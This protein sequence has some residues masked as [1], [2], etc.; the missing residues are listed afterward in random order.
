MRRVSIKEQI[1]F[2]L[3]ENRIKFTLMLIIIILGFSAGIFFAGSLS[4][5][6]GAEL[7]SFIREFCVNTGLETVPLGNIFKSAILSHL[8]LFIIIFLSGFSVIFVPV[9]FCALGLKMFEIGFTIGFMSLYFGLKGFLLAFAG[10]LSQII[11]LLPPIV[12]FGVQAINYANERKR[13]KTTRMSNVKQNE[14]QEFL[15]YINSALFCL[16]F[17]VISCLV[18]TFIT[19]VFIRSIA[20]ALLAKLSETHVC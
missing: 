7:S 19:P 20:P 10:A 11:L 9:I 17:I 3:E 18:E 15:N 13:M 12:L 8:R 2:Y 6:Q 5:D 16:V 14:R 4:T 1:I